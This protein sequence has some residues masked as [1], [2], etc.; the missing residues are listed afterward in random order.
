MS[1]KD[2]PLPDNQVGPSESSIRIPELETAV[3][4]YVAAD[5]WM[6]KRSGW[7]A[8]PLDIGHGR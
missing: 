2:E 5:F 6:E 1:L 3:T 7:V 4:R 8:S